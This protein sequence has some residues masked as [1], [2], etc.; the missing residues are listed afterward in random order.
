MIQRVKQFYRAVTARITIEDR[1]WVEETLPAAAQSLFYAMHPADQYH[2]LNVA[3]TAMRL[4]GEAPAG[5]RDLLLRAALLH[6]V[7][8][9]QGDMDIMGKV[10]AVLVK[11]FAP[12][13][14][15]QLAETKTGWLGHILYVYYQHPEIGAVKLEGIGMKEEASIIRCHHRKKTENDPPELALLRAADELN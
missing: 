8:R 2:A 15:R 5:D 12:V 9:V 3:K 1:A 13:K 10:L 7:G 14:A 6:D 4:W 11:H